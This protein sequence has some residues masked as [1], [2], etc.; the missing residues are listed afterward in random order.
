MSFLRRTTTSC[1]WSLDSAESPVGALVGTRAAASTAR[2]IHALTVCLRELADDFDRR[3]GEPNGHVLC[4]RAIGAPSRPAGAGLPM[5]GILVVL[6]SLGVRVA[7]RS[8]SSS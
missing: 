1:A 7:H 8:E 3:R 4:E 6:G 5:S 2:R